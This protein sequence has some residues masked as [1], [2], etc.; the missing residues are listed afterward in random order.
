MRGTGTLDGTLGRMLINRALRVST[1]LAF[2]AMAIAASPAA[3][4]ETAA[5]TQ[6]SGAVKGEVTGSLGNGDKEFSQL[7]ASWKQTEAPA[8]TLAAPRQTVSVP[9]SMPLTAATMTS[10]FGMRTH[11][12]LGG[13]RK[14]DGIDLAAPTGTPVYATADGVVEKAS[15]YG[16]YGNFIEIAHGGNMETRFGHLSGYNVHEGDK[17]QKGDLIGYVGTTGRS[18]GPH[19]HYEVRVD[20]TPVDPRPYM[21]TPQMALAEGPGGQGGE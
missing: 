21:I 20:G 2:A 10:S 14:H 7:F 12:V 5:A 8:G 13:R 15:W 9:S 4:N 16:G 6:M 3:A 11:P 17:V 1:S 18:T 19:L